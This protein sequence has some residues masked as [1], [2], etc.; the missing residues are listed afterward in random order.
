VSDYLYSNKKRKAATVTTA[1]AM[2][3]ILK[4]K[5]NEKNLIFCLF[6]ALYLLLIRPH[7]AGVSG[8]QK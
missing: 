5:K 1:F 2:L 3:L 4:I 8:P 7:D 6:T